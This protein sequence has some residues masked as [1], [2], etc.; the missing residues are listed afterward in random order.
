[1]IIQGNSKSLNLSIPKTNV[2]EGEPDERQSSSTSPNK[3]AGD[4]LFR[5][6]YTKLTPCKVDL[7]NRIK[8]KASELAELYDEVDILINSK[9]SMIEAGG[10]DWEPSEEQLEEVKNIMKAGSQD[11]SGSEMTVYPVKRVIDKLAANQTA[12]IV[13]GV[14][15]LEDSVYRVVKALTAGDP[16]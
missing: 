6:K 10:P 3:T 1:M 9:T 8:A 14:R 16:E 7:H 5:A 13:L 15:H 12:N 11:P 2:F 4:K